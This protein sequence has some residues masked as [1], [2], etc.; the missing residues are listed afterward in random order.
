[1]LVGAGALGSE[2]LKMFCEMRVG[3]KEGSVIVVDDDNLNE[4]N[5]NRMCLTT[6]SDLGQSKSD[7]LLKKSISINED[8][9]LQSIKEHICKSLTNSKISSSVWK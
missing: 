1:M 9:N 6:K 5:I 7:L 8:M 4:Y 2:F 3:C